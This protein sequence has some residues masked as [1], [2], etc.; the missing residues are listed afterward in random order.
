MCCP[1][2]EYVE[3]HV[4]LFRMGQSMVSRSTLYIFRLCYLQFTVVS[5]SGRSIGIVIRNMFPY[6]GER[7]AAVGSYCIKPL[8]PPHHAASGGQASVA[9]TRPVV[10]QLLKLRLFI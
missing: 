6:A 5:A 8:Y 4:P 10:G 2:V 1:R 3:S 9:S 7:L